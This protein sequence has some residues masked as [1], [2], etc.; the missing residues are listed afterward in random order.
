MTTNY[1]AETGSISL[2]GTP[3]TLTPIELNKSSDFNN[4]L[5]RKYNNFIGIKS[6]DKSK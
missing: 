4:W 1:P 6:S 2:N 5:N 3:Q